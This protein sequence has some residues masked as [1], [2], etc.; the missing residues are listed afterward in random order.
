MQPTQI[1][2]GDY[3]TFD[4]S[5]DNSHV[6]IQVNGPSDQI[7]IFNLETGGSQR[8]QAPGTTRWPI[9]HGTDRILFA[10]F[11][12]NNHSLAIK[13]VGTSN[14]PDILTTKIDS[15]FPDCISPDGSIFF[16]NNWATNADIRT[17][18][19]D[20]PYNQQDLIATEHNEWGTVIS[21]DSRWIAYTSDHDG[22]Y[23]I[24]VRSFPLSDSR[25]WK[26]SQN[27]GE[28]PSW[29]P[30]TNELF[31][32]NGSQFM[33]VQYEIE[34]ESEFKFQEPRVAFEGRLENVSGISYRIANDGQRI[35]VLKPV[36]D[37]TQIVDIR[38]VHNW[39]TELTRLATSPVNQPP[40]P[41][42][43]NR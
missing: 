22:Q 29:S 24:Y 16:Y 4:L 23:N 12:E 26:V 38:I 15:S 34:S 41:L 32:R 35:L 18:S 33:S 6:A 25:L 39:F 31:Y 36:F 1:K 30:T 37:V 20:P 8:I 19:L 2:A 14:P 3:G 9:W 10:W 28:E 5:P 11:N 43:T 21:P 40:S 27:M 7:H 42:S 17:V 13:E